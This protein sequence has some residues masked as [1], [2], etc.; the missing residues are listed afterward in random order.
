MPTQHLRF[1][2]LLSGVRKLTDRVQSGSGCTRTR[3]QC[4]F[5]RTCQPRIDRVCHPL[6]LGLR[7]QGVVVVQHVLGF[8]T[9]MRQVPAQPKQ[10]GKQAVQRGP[11]LS[12]N[13]HNVLA[14]TFTIRSEVMTALMQLAGCVG[15]HCR[16]QARMMVGLAAPL[17]ARWFAGRYRSELHLVCYVKKHTV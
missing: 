13:W 7:H 16:P 15:V 12:P 1:Q 10:A 11:G 2:G 5:I 3:S 17:P 14:H 9:H 6:G 4:P 8:E